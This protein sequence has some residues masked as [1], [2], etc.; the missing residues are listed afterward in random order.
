[1][2]DRASEQFRLADQ[3]TDQPSMNAEASDRTRDQ[4]T[5]SMAMVN[6]LW[7]NSQSRQSAC[8]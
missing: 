4:A 7:E 6:Q 5:N 1:M 2:N 8:S 3:A